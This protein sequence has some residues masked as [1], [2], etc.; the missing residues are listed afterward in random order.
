MNHNSCLP[1]RSYH[2]L[3]AVRMWQK[4]HI[5][6]LQVQVRRILV[7]H[8][9]HSL[10]MLMCCLRSL[11]PEIM[12]EKS[13]VG[14]AVKPRLPARMLQTPS[15]VVLDPPNQPTCYNWIPWVTSASVTGSRRIILE[16]PPNAW[17]TK[18]MYL[19]TIVW[20]HYILVQMVSGRGCSITQILNMWHWFWDGQWLDAGSV[21]GIL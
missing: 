8:E 3:R 17:P 6:R 5:V 18:W 2:L 1:L 16:S 19:L 21:S 15:K 20:S 13:C 4:W 14:P 9:T 11:C 12:L 10:G 7:S